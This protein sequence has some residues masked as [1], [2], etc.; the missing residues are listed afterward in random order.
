MSRRVSAASA[1][2]SRSRPVSVGP[3]IPAFRSGPSPVQD[4]SPILRVSN[5]KVAIARRAAT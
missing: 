2:S 3:F 4:P 5:P 1:R